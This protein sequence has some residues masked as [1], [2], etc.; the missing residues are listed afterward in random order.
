MACKATLKAQEVIEEHK[1][2]IEKVHEAAEICP[3]EYTE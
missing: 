1:D 3:D 2:K